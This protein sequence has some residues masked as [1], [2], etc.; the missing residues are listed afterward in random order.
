MLEALEGVKI[1]GNNLIV[2]SDLGE[3]M[4]R[5]GINLFVIFT[6]VRLIFYPIYR[7]KSHVF[8]YFLINMSV[9]L[10]CILLGGVK[11]KLGFAFGLFAVFSIIRY[12]TEQIPIKQ[13]TYLFVVIIIAV[14]NALASKNVSYA[15]LVFT[16]MV[17]IIC[18]Y[19]LEKN[20]LHSSEISKKIKYEKIE[21]IKPENYD[22]LLED[23]IDRTGLD[24]HKVKIDDINFLNDT[25]KITIYYFEARNGK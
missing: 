15:E 24:I 23:L 3:L 9:F 14:I 21:F 5:M 1:F 19:V 18:I 20:W 25:A 13:M 17:I 6:I 2:Y 16:N 10:V 12:R 4:L 22:Q 8:T 7:E 11:L